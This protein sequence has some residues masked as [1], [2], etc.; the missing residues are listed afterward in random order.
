MWFEL[1]QTV[2]VQDPQQLQ[3]GQEETAVQRL[4]AGLRHV[5][6][7]SSFRWVHAGAAGG[8]RLTALFSEMRRIIQ[9][10]L[11]LIDVA[12]RTW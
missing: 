3:R 5:C 11:S 1:P 7:S 4:P 10:I 8:G 9:H 2:C 6:R 12:W